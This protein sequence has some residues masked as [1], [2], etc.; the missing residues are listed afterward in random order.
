ETDPSAVSQRR[1]EEGTRLTGLP[2]WPP[3][4]VIHVVIVP[5][6]PGKGEPAHH[7]A[8]IRYVLATPSPDS[9]VPE[10]SNARLR[11]LPIDEAITTVGEDNLRITLQRIAEIGRKSGRLPA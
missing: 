9:A 10:D 5:V 8:D 11:W 4:A 6:P 2:P 3:S 1:A 7:H